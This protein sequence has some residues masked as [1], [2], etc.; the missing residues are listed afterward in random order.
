MQLQ[1]REVEPLIIEEVR[2]KRYPKLTFKHLIER[3]VRIHKLYILTPERR[4]VSIFILYDTETDYYRVIRGPSSWCSVGVRQNE[5]G[6]IRRLIC[7]NKLHSEPLR[8]V[9]Q[10]YVRHVPAL[11]V[12]VFSETNDARTVG[13]RYLCS[14]TKEYKYL[15]QKGCEESLATLGINHTYVRN[16]IDEEY[17]RRMLHAEAKRLSPDLDLWPET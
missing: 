12:V 10:K 6:H 2:R 16:R 17:E 9:R 13:L 1:L 15:V 7:A 14:I 8:H 3:T 5:T 4:L 11:D